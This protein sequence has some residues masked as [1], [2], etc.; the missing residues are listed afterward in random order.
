MK[1]YYIFKSYIYIVTMKYLGIYYHKDNSNSNSNNKPKNKIKSNNNKKIY[2]KKYYPYKSLFHNNN[3]ITFIDKRNCIDQI[4]IKNIAIDIKLC[5]EKSSN[6]FCRLDCFDERFDCFDERIHKIFDYNYFNNFLW[7]D[8]Q[9]NFYETIDS[10][11]ISY[12]IT[13]IANDIGM[14]YKEIITAYVILYSIVDSDNYDIIKT[15]TFRILWLGIC[16]LSIKLLNDDYEFSFRWINNQLKEKIVGLN[17]DIL[18]KIEYKLLNIL[19]YKFPQGDIY[20]I[21][22]K[23]LL[24]DSS[25]NFN[26]FD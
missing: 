1:L 11:S 3:N 16:N 22:S 2:L 20:D 21:I 18:L 4:I 12:Y 8:S 14:C 9:H 10:L 23:E 17:V 15:Y 19:N 24:Y 25:Y 26:I 13:Y 7:H 5:F 6:H